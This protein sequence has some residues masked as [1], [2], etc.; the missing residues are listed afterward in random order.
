MLLRIRTTHRSATDLGF[1]LHKNPARVQSFQ[2]VFLRVL[3]DQI[4]D[5]GP[6]I[7][8]RAFPDVQDTNP[9]NVSWHGEFACES[10][11][12]RYD[13]ASINATAKGPSSCR[14]PAIRAIVA[15]LQQHAAEVTD[16]VKRGMDAMHEA[17]MKNMHG[18]PG[19]RGRGNP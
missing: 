6:R 4:P 5:S 9:R 19:P 10:M 18:L 15:A 1:L 7:L 12:S 8:R 2:H 3:D 14:H 11:E 16:L 17:M 13:G